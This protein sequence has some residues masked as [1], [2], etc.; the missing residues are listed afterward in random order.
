MRHKNL[1][2]KLA[3]QEIENKKIWDVIKFYLICFVISMLFL[4]VAI[5]FAYPA[6]IVPADL[7]IRAIIGEASNQGYRGMLALASGIRNRGTLQGVYG[8]KAKHVD[9]E[10]EWVWE[11]A[12]KAWDESEFNRTHTGTHW[13]NIKAFG[14]PYWAK[15]MEVVYSFK[16]HVF[17]K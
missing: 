6:A 2:V 11:L 4:M 3:F 10:P 17:Y 9:N 1:V 5:S 8:L 16:D 7:A 12:K 14:E 15:T 13:E